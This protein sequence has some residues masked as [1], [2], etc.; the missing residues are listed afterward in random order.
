MTHGMRSYLRWDP[1]QRTY[2]SYDHFWLCYPCILS[3]GL[4]LEGDGADGKCSQV[5]LQIL[6]NFTII[7]HLFPADDLT[8][9]SLI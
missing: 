1:K 7:T 3:K 4:F 6:Y 9:I 2:L 5:K 8:L